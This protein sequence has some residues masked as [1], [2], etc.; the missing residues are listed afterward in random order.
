MGRRSSQ[1]F[2]PVKF[3]FLHISYI[4]VKWTF[5]QRNRL[6][7]SQDSYLRGQADKLFEVRLKA[8]GVVQHRLRE[9]I[10]LIR[11]TA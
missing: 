7:I 3:A 2:T 10:R 6:R 4:P 9:E 1:I 5:S 8:E 11:L